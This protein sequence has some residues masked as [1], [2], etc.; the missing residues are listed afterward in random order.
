MG[1]LSLVIISVLSAF[2]F[3]RAQD[4]SEAIRFPGEIQRSPFGRNAENS[5]RGRDENFRNDRDSSRHTANVAAAVNE[6]RAT[7][8][9]TTG[10]A[11]R[12]T[13]KTDETT[14]ET[15]TADDEPS[16]D[17]RFLV[18]HAR[19]QKTADKNCPNGQTRTYNG[20][21]KQAFVDP[22]D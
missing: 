15:Q 9:D 6:R 17:T 22:K 5:A 21:C 3:S 10:E 7:S 1:R 20:E 14:A 12:K 11:P 8:T 13:D 4:G 18:K 16:V 19:R 2:V